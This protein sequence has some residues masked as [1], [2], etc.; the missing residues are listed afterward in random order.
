MRKRTWGRLPIVALASVLV[1]LAAG[2]FS[3]FTPAAEARGAVPIDDVQLIQFRQGFLSRVARELSW[4]FT[5]YDREEL[6]I[7]E[8]VKW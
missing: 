2:L 1:L 3:L 5:K 6:R 7:I 4:Y 8:D